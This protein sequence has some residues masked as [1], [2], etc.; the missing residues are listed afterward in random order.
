[1]VCF[2]PRPN[3]KSQI[4][5]SSF[6]FF[7]IIPFFI[8]HLKFKPQRYKIISNKSTANGIQLIKNQI[9]KNDIF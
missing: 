8:K 4:A 9:H 7:A 2:V 6:C 3:L 5:I 1:M